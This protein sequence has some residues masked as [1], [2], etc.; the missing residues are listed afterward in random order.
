M[1]KPTLNVTPEVVEEID[2]FAGREGITRT[3]AMR[4]ILSLVKVS[5]QEH[6]RGRS[7]GVIRD[8]DGKLDVVAKLIGV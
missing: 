2:L 7:L 4:R 5:N 6:D 8:Q 1:Q 3:E